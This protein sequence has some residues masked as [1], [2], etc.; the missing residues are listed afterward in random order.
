MVRWQ[1]LEVAEIEKFLISRFLRN[2]IVFTTG[3]STNI[4]VVKQENMKSP[5]QGQIAKNK[6]RLLIFVFNKND[7]LIFN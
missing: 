4:P 7:D 1:K 5:Q 3:A 6:S 2:T